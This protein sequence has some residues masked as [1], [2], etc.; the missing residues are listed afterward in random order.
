[1]ECKNCKYWFERPEQPIMGDCLKI[2]QDDLPM[3][4]GCV[5]KIEEN[6]QTIV[7][8]NG[9]LTGVNFGCIH[10]VTN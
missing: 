2:S 1:M 7:I 5:G 9:V 3:E 10:F 8:P 6:G 4:D